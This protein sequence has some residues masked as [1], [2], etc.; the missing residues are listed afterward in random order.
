MKK[1]IGWMGL[2]LLA[3]WPCWAQELTPN[4][5]W[6]EQ[7]DGGFVFPTTSSAAR[8]YGRGL[9]GDILVGY[10]L[11][12]QFSLGLDLG[13]YDCD[14]RTLGTSGGQW[15]YTSALVVARYAIGQGWIRPFLFFGA[16]FAFNDVSLTPKAGDSVSDSETDPLLSPGAG[17]LFIVGDGVALFAQSRVDL[18]FTSSLSGLNFQNPAIFIPVKAG[19]SIFPQ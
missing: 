17:V 8:N 11:D 2:L 13:Y 15:N 6:I 12:P 16:G 3:A 4:Q 18:D 1:V 5:R 19:V 9:G 7:A 10:R 14:Q